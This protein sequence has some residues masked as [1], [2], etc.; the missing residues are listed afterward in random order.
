MRKTIAVLAC[1][2]M[3]SAA[4]AAVI[5]KIKLSRDVPEM[6][7]EA[8]WDEPVVDKGSAQAP[9]VTPKAVL[10]QSSVT[11]S[12]KTRKADAAFDIAGAM[13]AHVPAGALFTGWRL[14]DG[15]QV[16]C[17]LTAEAPDAPGKAALAVCLTPDGGATVRK[18]GK[19]YSDA[20]TGTLA[21]KPALTAGFTETDNVRAVAW[22]RPALFFSYHQS[23]EK[24]GVLREPSNTG[25]IMTVGQLALGTRV[26]LGAVKGDMVTLEHRTF[27]LDDYTNA[28]SA[29]QDSGSKQAEA[30]VDLSAGP[31]TVALGG[32]SF[33]VSRTAEKLITVEALTPSTVDWSIDPATGRLLIDGGPYV[34][35][36]QEI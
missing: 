19:R 2:L 9:S 17:T 16:Q 30:T 21:A 10:W 15:S 36:A 12:Q 24:G 25:A 8:A 11:F 6:V 28:L 29:R 18:K 35:G 31:Q 26:V 27:E 20:V 14:A 23:S 34:L 7:A 1:V 32:G 4:S 22:P 33:R 5:V 13:P 3:S